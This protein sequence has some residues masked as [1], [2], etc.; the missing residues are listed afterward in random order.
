MP[1]PAY[2]GQVTETPDPHVI[3]DGLLPTPFTAGEIRAALRGGAIIRIR[4]EFPD[5]RT[6]DRINRFREGDDEGATLDRWS[7]E[8]PAE[9]SSSRV[10]WRELQAHAAFPAEQTVVRADTLDDHPLG[11]VECLRY[12]VTDSDGGAV[13]WFALAHPGM[14]VRYESTD[15]TGTTRTTVQEI[16]AG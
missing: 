6:E 8:S 4:T 7:T 5:S 16:G 14:P 15:T 10:T 3:A 11:R 9:V 2:P 1:R 12:D 13:F